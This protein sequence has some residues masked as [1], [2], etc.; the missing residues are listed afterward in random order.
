[1]DLVQNKL[2]PI[3]ATG[4]GRPHGAL[5]RRAQDPLAWCVPPLPAHARSLSLATS[6]PASEFGVSCPLINLPH[7]RNCS[8]ACKKLRE[9]LGAHKSDDT[10]RRSMFSLS[11]LVFHSCASE[12]TGSILKQSLLHRGMLRVEDCQEGHAEE[13]KARGGCASSVLLIAFSRS[14]E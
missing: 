3:P 14:F 4:K 10:D 12:C 9:I 7:L 8:P 13:V 6:L 5:H 1:M 2:T 11:V